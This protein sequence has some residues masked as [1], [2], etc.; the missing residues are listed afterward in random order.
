MHSAWNHEH[1][2]TWVWFVGTLSSP[3]EFELV[4]QLC[5]SEGSPFKFAW[6]LEVQLSNNRT[7]HPTSRSRKGLICN[8]SKTPIMS[9]MT[10]KKP[11]F[12]FQDRFAILS[13]VKYS[14]KASAW[15][16]SI[17]TLSE[18]QN[19]LA[20]PSVFFTICKGFISSA[21]KR[22]SS[23]TSSP[24]MKLRIDFR[25]QMLAFWQIKKWQM[26]SLQS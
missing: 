25:W 18:V 14:N 16:S 15:N 23:T 21:K 5:W 7:T 17:E 22:G 4:L 3:R 11:Y 19:K 2:F 10:C 13:K 20:G 1:N 26:I 9:S 24:A 12:F 6:R 8:S